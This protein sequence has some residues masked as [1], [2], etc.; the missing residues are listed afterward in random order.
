MIGTV[1]LPVTVR[2]DTTGPTTTI[3]PAETPLPEDG[4]A[5]VLAQAAYR[6]SATPALATLGYSDL[7]HT[8]DP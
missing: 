8:I 6:V 1:A 7:V 5:E 4:S 3:V 2:A